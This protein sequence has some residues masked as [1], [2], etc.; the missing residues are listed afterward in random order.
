MQLRI[1]LDRRET[2]LVNCPNERLLRSDKSRQILN[3]SDYEP[4]KRNLNRYCLRSLRIRLK[5]VVTMKNSV[6]VPVV[7]KVMSRC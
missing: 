2:V 3:L 1:T 4:K 7:M 5:T 6:I